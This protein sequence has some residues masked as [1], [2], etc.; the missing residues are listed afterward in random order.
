MF[1]LALQESLYF[2]TDLS[3]RLCYPWQISTIFYALGNF[4]HGSMGS[5]LGLEKV[6]RNGL[7]HHGSQGA[8]CHKLFCG[9]NWTKPSQATGLRQSTHMDP[10]HC[11]PT[12]LSDASLSDL[13]PQF[14][15]ASPRD[16]ADG[17]TCQ[18]DTTSVPHVYWNSTSGNHLSAGKP[19]FCAHALTRV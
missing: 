10:T 19:I 12:S 6:R 5:P 7:N 9:L 13:D 17:P 1:L 16:V 3:P 2:V 4:R 14:F 8:F 18:T 15:H 11:A